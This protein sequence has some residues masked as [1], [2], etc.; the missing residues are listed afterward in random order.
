MSSQPVLGCLVANGTARLA[1]SSLR[2][3]YPAGISGAIDA[4]ASGSSRHFSRLRAK[5]FSLHS[6]ADSCRKVR[7]GACV[8]DIDEGVLQRDAHTAKGRFETLNLHRSISI[9]QEKMGDP[10]T[11]TQQGRQIDFL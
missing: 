5:R 11:R 8:A 6:G 2:N 1:N 7:P 10:L 4:G 9:L 3:D